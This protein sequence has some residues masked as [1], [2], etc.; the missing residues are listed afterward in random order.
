MGYAFDE[1]MSGTMSLTADPATRHPIEFRANVRVPWIG[2]KGTM[3][4]TIDAGPLVRGAAFDGRMLLR[5][6]LG[7]VIRYELSFTGTDG[8]RYQLAG[9]KDIRWLDA[10]RTWTE[11]P[12]ELTDDAGR[13]VATAE[14][15][16]NIARDWLAFGSSFRVA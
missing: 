3:T 1:T 14:L 15:R 4:G 9:Q 16:M 13:V 7:R 11:L 10:R 12:A 2:G 5:P 6:M 8:R